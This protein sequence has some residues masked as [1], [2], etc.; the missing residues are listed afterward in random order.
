[1]TEYPENIQELF[2]FQQTQDDIVASQWQA[3]CLSYV[4]RTCDK[5]CIILTGQLRFVGNPEWE[6][7][8]VNQVLRSAK[9]KLPD[10]TIDIIWS[11]PEY[12][13][14]DKYL[15]SGRWTEQGFNTHLSGL[16]IKELYNDGVDNYDPKQIEDVFFEYPDLNEGYIP[17]KKITQK[18]PA[19]KEKF[20]NYAKKLFAWADSFE[21]IWYDPAELAYTYQTAFADTDNLYRDTHIIESLYWAN[22]FAVTELIYKHKI[23]YFESMTRNSIILRTRPDIWNH[24]IDD[25][26]T[27]WNWVASHWLSQPSTSAS[28]NYENPVD[29]PTGAHMYHMENNMD[30][31]PAISIQSSKFEYVKGV[32][33]C[34]DFWFIHDLESFRI[35]AN[36]FKEWVMQ[37]AEIRYS[38]FPRRG[39]HLERYQSDNIFRFLIKAEKVIMKFFIDQQVTITNSNMDWRLGNMMLNLNHH[40]NWQQPDRSRWLWYEWDRQMLEKFSVVDEQRIKEWTQ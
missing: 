9:D 14:V 19:R 20:E 40:D 17:H 15:T 33:E 7:K 2:N 12:D 37:D 6:K 29:V 34:S 5:L 13:Q 31:C 22:Q 8:F 16:P 18:I 10:I 1:M 4:D 24:D 30:L 23:D 39:E 25:K 28:V 21:I 26:F 27:V 11:V 38:R 35:L 36:R 32:P 3:D